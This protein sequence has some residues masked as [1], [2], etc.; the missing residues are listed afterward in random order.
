MGFG[1]CSSR[2]R[3]GEIRRHCR[4]VVVHFHTLPGWETLTRVRVSGTVVT[5][6]I[7]MSV[8]VRPSLKRVSGVRNHRRRRRHRRRHTSLLF[9]HEERCLLWLVSPVTLPTPSQWRRS[10]SPSW[11]SEWLDP[12][13]NVVDDTVSRFTLSPSMTNG[14]SGSF[15]NTVTT[16]F[17]EKS[18]VVSRT[19]DLSYTKPVENHTTWQDK[20]P[21]PWGITDLRTLRTLWKPKSVVTWWHRETQMW[22]PIYN[23]EGLTPLYLRPRGVPSYVRVIPIR[24]CYHGTRLVNP[25]TPHSLVLV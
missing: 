4:T 21:S 6:L 9:P 23:L 15:S 16:L 10:E 7:V 3:T 20:S 2:V 5:L 12:K 17:L 8:G 1:T 25:Q 18:V 14:R 19:R 13:I 22:P 11:K 24:E